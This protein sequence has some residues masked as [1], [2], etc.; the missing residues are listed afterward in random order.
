MHN[1]SHPCLPRARAFVLSNVWLSSPAASTIESCEGLC[2]SAGPF[3]SGLRWTSHCHLGW[4]WVTVIYGYLF[5]F[6]SYIII[7]DPLLVKV[8]KIASQS[9]KHLLNQ[10]TILTPSQVPGRSY[11]GRRWGEGVRDRIFSG[12]DGRAPVFEHL[13]EKTHI[14]LI[15]YMYIYIN[16]YIYKYIY[17]CIMFMWIP[18]VSIWHCGF[19]A[20]ASTASAASAPARGSAVAGVFHAA[21]LDEYS[22]KSLD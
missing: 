8:H 12:E 14:H 7:L 22:I 19:H 18:Q 2:S 13:N 6:R 9:L 20:A 21:D 17:I 1:L 10:L 15:W 11:N 4:F 5:L 16:I 3:W